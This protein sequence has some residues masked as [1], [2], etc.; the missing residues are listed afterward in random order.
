MKKVTTAKMRK[1]LDSLVSECDFIGVELMA[2]K[3]AGREEA[4]EMLALAAKCRAQLNLMR[5]AYFGDAEQPEPV[6]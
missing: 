2:A 5:T 3:E 4:G 6:Q 1:Q